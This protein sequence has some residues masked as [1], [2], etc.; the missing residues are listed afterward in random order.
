MLGT[1]TVTTYVESSAGVS[2]GGRTGLTSLTVAGLF[3]LSLFFAPLFISIPGAATSPALI[4]VGLFMISP[5]KEINFDETTEA[6]PAFLTILFMVTTYS[7]ANGIMYGALSW[8]LL[9]LFTKKGKDI[10]ITM[11][12]IAV[13]LVI[14]LLLG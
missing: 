1:S 13:L 9:K 5:V 3:V 8:I 12:V 7:I 10:S 4:L 6:V 2:E 14:K 11:I